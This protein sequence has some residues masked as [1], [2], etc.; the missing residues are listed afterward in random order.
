MKLFHG[1]NVVVECPRILESNRV[2]DFG[3]GFYLTSDLDQAVKW[4]KNVTKRRGKGVPMV[5]EY[6][7][8]KKAMSDLKV[9]KFHSPDG[10]WLH[11]ISNNRKNISHGE[12]YD[13]VFGPVANDNTMPVLNLF[14]SGFL[15]EEETI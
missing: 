3:A 5:S 15:D 2:L 14:L 9:L 10:D 7:I 11:Y 8:S 4:A 12:P 1:S 13:I 6:H